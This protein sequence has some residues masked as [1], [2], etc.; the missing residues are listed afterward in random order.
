MGTAYLPKAKIYV[1]TYGGGSTFEDRMSAVGRYLENTSRFE[2]SFAEE[3]KKLADYTSPGG[4]TD[5]SMK[6]IT[7][8]TGAIDPRH[9]TPENLALALWGTASAKTATPIV[10]ES[11]FKIVPKG[12]LATKRIID[13]SVTPIV[14]KGAT[15]ILSADIAAISPSG[16]LIA[17]T[18]TT[19]GV[20]SGD[21]V[22]IDY[23]PKASHSIEAVVSSA[24]EVSILAEGINEVD[25]KY[26]VIK[27]W[28]AKLGV[29]QNVPFIADDYATLALSI[30]IQKDET[31]VGAGLSQYLRIETQD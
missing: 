2:V 6:R 31:I 3:E 21:A 10:A 26:T 20:T 24:P 25:G 28:K 9:F 18:L 23:T 17:S 8:V 7:D 15:T 5:A 11:G 27:I 14:K 16:I 12:F 4:G 22:T 30:T 13:T 19:V 29:A 1:A